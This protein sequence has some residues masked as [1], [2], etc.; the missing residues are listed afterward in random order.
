MRIWLV[1]AGVILAAVVIGV[2]GYLI[3]ASTPIAPRV[4]GQ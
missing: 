2:V 1:A 3:S 4:D